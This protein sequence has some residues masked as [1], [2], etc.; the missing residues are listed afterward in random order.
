MDA[1]PL[2]RT[3]LAGMGVRLEL[4]SW[5]YG[6]GRTVEEAADDLV[7][8][9]TI[10]ARALRAGGF[11]LHPEVQPPDPAYL[12]FLWELGEVAGEPGRVRARVFGSG[13]PT[14]G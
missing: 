10:Q 9:L 6:N 8:R 12:D 2:L 1:L 11:R 4:G 3:H 7:A 5:S 13:G 14:R